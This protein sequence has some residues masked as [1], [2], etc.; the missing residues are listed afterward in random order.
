MRTKK[1]QLMI[2][3]L[4]Q[5]HMKPSSTPCKYQTFFSI[6]MFSSLIPS[7]TCKLQKFIILKKM[8]GIN[9]KHGGDDS[10]FKK[11]HS[12]EWGYLRRICN[13]ILGMEDLGML[14]T[15]KCCRSVLFTKNMKNMCL[16]GVVNKWKDG[17]LLLLFS[18]FFMT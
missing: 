8:Q 1:L 4:P 14:I 9:S 6:S 11:N 16:I 13:S 12:T 18:T 17:D 5:K 2:F 7:L 3:C 10:V 15:Y